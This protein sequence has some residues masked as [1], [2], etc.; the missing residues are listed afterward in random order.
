MRA[1]E[2][3]AGAGGLALGLARAGFKHAALIDYDEDAYQTLVINARNGHFLTRD[4]QALREDVRKLPYDELATQPTD[5]LAGG[6][7]CQ[8]FSQGGLH[9]GP[10]DPRDMFPAFIE[11][12]YRLRPR[13]FLIENVRGLARPTFA[14]Y[15]EYIILRLTYPWLRPRP[16]EG[17][18]DHLA[19]LEDVHTARFTGDE[20]SYNVTFQMLNAADYG[21]PQHRERLFIVG[22]RQDLGVHWSFPKRTHHSV[23]LW[24]EQWVTGAYWKRHGMD[25]RQG[26]VAKKPKNIEKIKRLAERLLSEEP[27]ARPWLTVRD[28]LWGNDPLPDPRAPHNIPN[29]LYWPGARAYPGHTGSALDEPAKTIKAG[30]HGVPGGE[31]MLRFADGSVRYL[32]V[33]EAARLQAFPDDYIFPEG[34]S[35]G[36]KLVG[37]AV[38]VTLGEIIGRSI[39]R[40]LQE[41]LALS[42]AAQGEASQELAAPNQTSIYADSS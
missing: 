9:K 32:T 4:W 5:L 14:T 38:P 10:L 15:L 36:M 18:L 3:F 41:A 12:V 11:A 35:R 30:V 34:W 25:P 26:A 31:N 13:A 6:P 37:N 22:F 21:I 27:A 42:D 40:A 23:L 1:I 7:P 19:R 39:A 24:Y 16:D 20:R 17:W 8:P 2:L 33:R 29:H 28:A